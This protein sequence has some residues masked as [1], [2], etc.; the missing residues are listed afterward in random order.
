MTGS[1]NDRKVVRTPIQRAAIAL[2]RREMREY[3]SLSRRS[4]IVVEPP[5]VNLLDVIAQEKLAHHEH[6]TRSCAH[7]SALHEPC[8]M[9]ERT[10]QD[11]QAYRVA[12]TQRIKDLLSQLG[13]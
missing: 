13:E 10:E 8:A 2:V 7:G 6:G 1:N 4:R 12:A 9:C 5:R 11:C 3:D